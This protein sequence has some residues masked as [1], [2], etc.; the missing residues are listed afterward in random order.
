MRIRSGGERTAPSSP[1]L[2]PRTF[3]FRFASCSWR[4][5]AA[6]LPCPNELLLVS[7]FENDR[8]AAAG[9]SRR[10]CCG[11]D[12]ESF[13]SAAARRRGPRC[14]LSSSCRTSTT[15]AHDCASWSTAARDRPRSFMSRSKKARR[16]SAVCPEAHGEW[17]FSSS[18]SRNLRV[19]GKRKSACRCP[20]ADGWLALHENDDAE[21]GNT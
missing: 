18:S 14:W 13:S 16:S 6:L 11:S 2:P 1:P 17:F 4:Q 9:S 12:E 7:V 5:L 8:R 3:R 21:G 20:P 15:T 10:C 19:G